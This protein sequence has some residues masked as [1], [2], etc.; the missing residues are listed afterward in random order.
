MT[1]LRFN[2]VCVGILTAVIASA[3]ALAVLIIGDGSSHGEFAAALR[4]MED[5]LVLSLG[6]SIVFASAGLG[7]L[8]RYAANE[9]EGAQ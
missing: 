2:I 7:L 4:S 8:W 3:M 9:A 6:L 5:N 1:P